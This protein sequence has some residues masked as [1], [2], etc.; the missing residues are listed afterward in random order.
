MHA[1]AA[2][3]VAWWN[4]SW[5]RVDNDKTNGKGQICAIQTSSVESTSTDREF[6]VETPTATTPA[7]KTATMATTATEAATMATT[8]TTAVAAPKTGKQCISDGT[9]TLA[10]TTVP[11]AAG[12]IHSEAA[13]K[14]LPAS[15][16]GGT[17]RSM[18][19]R[20]DRRIWD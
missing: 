6:N 2:Q 7:I 11:S 5:T 20:G 3:N 9:T 13:T 10:A 15:V 12:H 19:G 18:I 1:R 14:W 17:N 16:V 8:T 4:R